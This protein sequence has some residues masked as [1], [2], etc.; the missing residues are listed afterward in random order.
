MCLT[1]DTAVRNFTVLVTLLATRWVHF[2]ALSATSPPRSYN[3][4][5]QGGER[6]MIKGKIKGCRGGRAEHH[7][8]YLLKRI[9]ME[10]YISQCPR[11]VQRKWAHDHFTNMFIFRAFQ[12]PWELPAR[13][14]VS[15]D[16]LRYFLKLGQCHSFFSTA[17]K[18]CACVHVFSYLYV[19]LSLQRFKACEKHERCG[20]GRKLFSRCWQLF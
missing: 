14:N 12:Q 5:S 2:W 17:Y 7:E 4:C 8:G 20:F 16:I 3:F 10:Q 1:T 9:W 15:T 19:L 11:T 6:D 13:H 18:K